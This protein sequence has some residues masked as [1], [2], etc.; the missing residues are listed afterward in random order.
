[1]SATIQDIMRRYKKHHRLHDQKS[2]K[3]LFDK[4]ADRVAIQMNDTHPALAVPELMRILVDVEGLDWEEAWK[5]TTAT[6][7]YTNHT[8]MPEALERWPVSLMGRVLPRHLEIIFEINHRFME[9]V[10]KKFPGDDDKCR[11]MSIIEEGNEKRVRMA[12]L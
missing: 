5:I 10:R 4:L 7:G 9:D 8:V 6:C 12:N 3:K 11:R 1:V 2:G